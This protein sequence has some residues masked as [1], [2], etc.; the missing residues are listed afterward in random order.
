MRRFVVLVVCVI[1]LVAFVA[2]RDRDPFFL[3]KRLR[4]DFAQD[5]IGARALLSQEELYPVLG[6]AFQ[7]IGLEW[8]VGHRSTHPPSAF[9]LALPLA[10]FNYPV[11]LR[12]WASTTRQTGPS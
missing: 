7:R 3:G 5:Y 4:A 11:A 6:P 9:L 1:V 8:E 12:C 2:R 10:S